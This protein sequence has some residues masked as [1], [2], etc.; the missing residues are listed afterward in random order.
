MVVPNLLTI[1]QF[2]EKH[3]AFS[4][5]GLRHQIFHAESNGLYNSG[6]ILRNGRRVLINEERFFGWLT[7]SNVRAS[8]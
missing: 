5:G 3:Q 2:C 7:D 8:R 4:E 6:A 1:K